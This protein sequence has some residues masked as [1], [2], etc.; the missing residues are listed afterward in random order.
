M[1]KFMTNWLYYGLLW[2]FSLQ[3]STLYTQDYLFSNLVSHEIEVRGVIGESVGSDQCT[4]YHL[5]QTQS[6]CPQEM[7][8]IH[9]QTYCVYRPAK[10]SRT[11]LS[12]ALPGE[13][14]VRP[15]VQVFKGLPLFQQ[16]IAPTLSVACDDSGCRVTAR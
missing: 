13:T 10:F 8:V 11:T 4:P 15:V 2:G 1:G 12:V 14:R 7:R 3:A 5:E 9:M 6:L 16:A